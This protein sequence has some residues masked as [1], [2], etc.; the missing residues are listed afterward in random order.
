MQL[1][2]GD[3]SGYRFIYLFFPKEL[4]S[5]TSPQFITYYPDY[6]LHKS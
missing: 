6:Y 2:M 3:T 1:F 4:Y 5:S